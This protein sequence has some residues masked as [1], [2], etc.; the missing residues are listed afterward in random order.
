MARPWYWGWLPLSF[1]LFSFKIPNDTTCAPGASAVDGRLCWQWPWA[2]HAAYGDACFSSNAFLVWVCDGSMLPF[3]ISR[4]LHALCQGDPQTGY[5]HDSMQPFFGI[6]GLHSMYHCSSTDAVETQHGGCRY[7]CSQSWSDA[8]FPS[9]ASISSL[10]VFLDKILT[11][12]RMF[13]CHVESFSSFV[14]CHLHPLDPI[15]RERRSCHLGGSLLRLHPAICGS[16]R[17]ETLS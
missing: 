17:P 3:P 10:V 8:M 14:R 15:W 7:T 13:L 11:P 12:P 16:E 5:S 4:M 6:T 9:Q 1:V 2:A